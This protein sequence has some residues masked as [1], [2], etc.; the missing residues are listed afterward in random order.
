MK[1]SAWES[2][3]VNK[4]PACVCVCAL[5]SAAERLCESGSRSLS[6]SLSRFWFTERN[7]GR[8]ISHPPGSLRSVLHSVSLVLAGRSLS[9]FCRKYPV[10]VDNSP[11]YGGFHLRSP[12]QSTCVCSGWYRRI[13]KRFRQLAQDPFGV[14]RKGHLSPKRQRLCAVERT[15]V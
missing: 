2:E 14:W 5:G 1:P 11:P 10:C 15:S 4:I 8:M 12:T 9:S 6:L 13:R 7:F 3:K